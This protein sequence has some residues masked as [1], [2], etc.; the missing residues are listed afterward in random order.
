[1]TWSL[2]IEE[3]YRKLKPI[4]G[5]NIDKLWFAYLVED[6]K[7]RRV[8]GQDISTTLIIRTVKGFHILLRV[9]ITY[10]LQSSR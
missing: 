9:T 8:I 4:I 7:W 3:L 2:D 1:M 10:N 5:E 6:G